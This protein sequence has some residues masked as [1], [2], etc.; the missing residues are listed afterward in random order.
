MSGE[1]IHLQAG[2][3]SLG[4]WGV[5]SIRGRAHLTERS[6]VGDR[7]HSVSAQLWKLQATGTGRPVIHKE[8]PLIRPQ[9][10]ILYTKN[11]KFT[12]N[13]S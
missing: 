8:T 3:F 12:R 10:R 4:T 13:L 9:L 7:G 11:P 2:V 5:A 6:A 1:Q